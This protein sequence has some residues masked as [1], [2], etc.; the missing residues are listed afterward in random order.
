MSGDQ[1][2]G[3][4]EEVRGGQTSRHDQL[5]GLQ[6]LQES[7]L[8][9]GDQVEPDV[10][11]ARPRLGPVEKREPQRRHLPQLAVSVPLRALGTVL[12]ES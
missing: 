6:P 9:V 4:V 1:V 8:E 7:R 5:I 11:A 3:G 10:L 12:R 2:P